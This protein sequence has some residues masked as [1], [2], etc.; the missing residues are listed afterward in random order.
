[1]GEVAGWNH[2]KWEIDSSNQENM[3]LDCEEQMQLNCCGLQMME[4]GPLL[5]HLPIFEEQL[6]NLDFYVKVLDF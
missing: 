6:E 5:P 4:D 2:V 3:C 1:M